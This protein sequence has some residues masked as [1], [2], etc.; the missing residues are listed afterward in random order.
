MRLYKFKIGLLSLLLLSA[1]SINSY[2][3]A[4]GEHFLTVDELLKAGFTQL[5]GL[6]L[7][8]LL[9]EKEV[10]VRDIET[11]AVYISVRN[12]DGSLDNRKIEKEKSQSMKYLLNAKLLARAPLLSEN[13]KY[14][15][16]G[17]ELISKDGIRTYHIKFYEKQGRMFGARDIDNGNVFYE[18]T[19]K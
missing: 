16:S 5:T 6:Q 1:S 8:E 7:I 14:E 9:N 11:D 17:D 4:D 15:V 2:V 3:F 18:L 19:V 12:E 13:A 10:E